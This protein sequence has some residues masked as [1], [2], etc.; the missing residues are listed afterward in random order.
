[1]T[2]SADNIIYPS[3]M[4]VRKLCKNRKTLQ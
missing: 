2:E 4:G 3:V 1:M